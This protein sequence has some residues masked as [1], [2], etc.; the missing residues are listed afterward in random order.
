[1]STGVSRTN[2]ESEPTDSTMTGDPSTTRFLG[3]AALL[4]TLSGMVPAFAAEPQ[5]ANRGVPT[6]RID[7]I[8]GPTLNTH[9]IVPP[10][11]PVVLAGR[12]ILMP[13][14]AGVSLSMTVA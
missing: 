2:G 11:A 13:F 14:D 7:E 9:R 8:Q 12:S 5:A 3:T 10:F 4:G 6:T 1:M